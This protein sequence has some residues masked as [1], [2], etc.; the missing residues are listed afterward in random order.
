MTGEKNLY[1]NPGQNG[2]CLK[3]DV[4]YY[5]QVWER[6][7]KL[8]PLNFLNPNYQCFLLMSKFRF[9]GGFQMHN[10]WK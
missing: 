2:A 8:V 6:L 7:Y 10:I 1:L 3:F 5:T 4:F 9:F